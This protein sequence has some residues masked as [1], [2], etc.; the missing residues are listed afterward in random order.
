[1]K[2]STGYTARNTAPLPAALFA[3]LTAA[4]VAAAVRPSPAAALEKQ[5]YSCNAEPWKGDSERFVREMLLKWRE[6]Y[7]RLSVGE[8]RI[9]IRDVLLGLEPPGER[10]QI[11]TSKKGSIL[12][13]RKDGDIRC[14]IEQP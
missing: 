4:A 12:F 2:S 5:V 13:E 14:S 11:Q 7:S 8:L 3:L 6:D 9:Y 10:Y 1:M